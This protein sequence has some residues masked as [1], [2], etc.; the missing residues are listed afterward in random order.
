MSDHSSVVEALRNQFGEGVT[1]TAVFRN[2]LSVFVEPGRIAEVCAFC[3]DDVRLSFEML[4]DL[5]AV[6]FLP[7]EPRFEVVYN[8]YSFRHNVR[9][10]LKVPLA[11][12][13]TIGTVE[14]VWKAANWLERE[15]FDLFGIVFENHSDLRRILLWDGYI[16][17]PLRKDFPLH[18]VPQ[19]VQYG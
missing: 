16:G 8:L 3:R 19:T 17:H 11:E 4:T 12:N 9:L 10:L 7:R 15:V 5:T 1:A 6:D 2:Q 14:G 18:G 13:E